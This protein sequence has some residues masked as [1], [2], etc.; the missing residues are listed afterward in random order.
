MVSDLQKKTIK[1]IVCIF[2]TSKLKGDY[3]GVARV[4]ADTGGI[5]YG[6]SQ[7]SLNSGSLGKLLQDYARRA[8][9]PNK[10]LLAPYLD[11]ALRKSATLNTDNDFYELLKQLGKDP[12]MQ[13]VQDE[14]FDKNFW[15]PAVN[16]CNENGLALPLSYLVIYD[17]KIHGSLDKVA[18][19]VKLPKPITEDAEKLW[20]KTY[21]E[22]RRDWLTKRSQLLAKTTYR[23]SE[24]MALIN[25]NNWDLD[26]PIRIRGV[27]ITKEA[28]Q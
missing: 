7:A 3:S 14:F 27:N 9:L 19:L 8:T 5:S 2:E 18:A 24:F 16:W 11:L 25:N 28:L 12:L 20:T 23:Q 15:Q 22:T 26:L 17:S 21:V 6:I 4:K 10:T 1:S 13:Q